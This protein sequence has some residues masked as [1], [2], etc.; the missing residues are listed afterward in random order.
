VSQRAVVT[1]ATVTATP[2]QIAIIRRGFG[3]I[4]DAGSV[5]QVEF[6]E[7]GDGTVTVDV[8]LETASS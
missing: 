1:H 7:T 5:Q 6:S 2:G 4:M 8:T 3:D